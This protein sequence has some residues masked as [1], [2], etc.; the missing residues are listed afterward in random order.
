[1]KFN[2]GSKNKQKVDALKEMLKEYTKQ[3]IRTALIHLENKNFY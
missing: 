3:A 1:M 2:I